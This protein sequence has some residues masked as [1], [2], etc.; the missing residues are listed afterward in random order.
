M[1]SRPTSTIEIS[2]LIKSIQSMVSEAVQAKELVPG[3]LMKVRL[4]RES[5][6]LRKI[7]ES[8]K[9]GIRDVKAH[10]RGDCQPV[11]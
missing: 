4:S 1:Q 7:L 10:S 5:E 8:T 6:A 3:V 11:G 2:D 9:K